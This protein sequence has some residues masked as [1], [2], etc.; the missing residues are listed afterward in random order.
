MR[1]WYGN[2]CMRSS[3]YAD[4]CAIWPGGLWRMESKM[5]SSDANFDTAARKKTDDVRGELTYAFS[6][7]T[8][9]R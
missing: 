3:G 5:S 2:E 6:V 4:A 9:A 1:D 7:L 8:N